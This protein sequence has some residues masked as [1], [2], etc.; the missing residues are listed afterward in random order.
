[1]SMVKIKIIKNG[2][3]KKEEAMK[4]IS[5]WSNKRGCINDDCMYIG[6]AMEVALRYNRGSDEK[7]EIFIDHVNDYGDI[8]KSKKVFSLDKKY[9]MLGKVEKEVI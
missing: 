8:V 9:D 6:N 2:S 5:V 3:Q 4:R 1:M 7:V